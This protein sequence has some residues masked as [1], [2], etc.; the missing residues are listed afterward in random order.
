MIKGI[1]MILVLFFSGKTIYKGLSGKVD[2]PYTKKY[3]VIMERRILWSIWEV[4][5]NWSSFNFAHYN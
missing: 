3:R 2:G 5:C 4:N 1:L